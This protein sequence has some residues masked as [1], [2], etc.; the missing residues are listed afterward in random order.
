[1]IIEIK[2]YKIKADVANTPE[3]LEKGLQEVINLEDNE[4]LL[5]DFGKDD[6]IS[7]WMDKTRIG[8]D[9]IFI[10]SLNRITKIVSRD[11]NS[12]Q[13]SIHQGRYVLEVNKNYCKRRGIKIG[14]TI[15]FEKKPF[16][17]NQGGTMTLY[18]DKGNAQMKM[19]GGE[20][21][22]SRVSTKEIISLYNKAN[23]DKSLI[24]LGLAVIKEVNAQNK[25]KPEYVED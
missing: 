24:E 6:M 1:M 9:L 11:P 8:L 17:F 18:D 16:K 13:Q 14:D 15:K 4:G 20:R 3:Q 23:D 2:G 19:Y 22:F 10:N 21:I 12:K 7:I 25:R 5:L